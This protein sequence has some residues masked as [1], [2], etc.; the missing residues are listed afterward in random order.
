MINKSRQA[1]VIE[2]WFGIDKLLFGKNAKNVLKGEDYDNY[3]SSKGALL[4]NLY[5]IYMKLGYESPHRFRNQKE[6]FLESVSLANKASKKAKKILMQEG[7]S[8]LLRKEIESIG[9]KEGLTEQQVAK[10]IVTKRRHAVALDEM[11]LGRPLK[12]GD[13][14]N[15]KDWKGKVLIDAHKVLRDSLI[16]IALQSGV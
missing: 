12:E 6:L 9:R 10:Y 5:E 3:L 8:K 14:S 11:L 15:L 13:T 2:H 4:S 7:V 1:A 16:E